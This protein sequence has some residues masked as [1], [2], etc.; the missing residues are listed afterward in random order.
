MC[1]FSVFCFNWPPRCLFGVVQGPFFSVAHDFDGPMG[2]RKRG[3]L[4]P[5]SE[6]PIVHAK[7]CAA[8]APPQGAAERTNFDRAWPFFFSGPICC[9][10]CVLEP[11][12]GPEK[13]FFRVRSPSTRKY[14]DHEA[15]PNCVL[16]ASF[17]DKTA[18]T[19][20]RFYKGFRERPTGVA[21]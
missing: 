14:N 17:R 12:V 8:I 11:P 18:T 7:S 15:C 10:H 20:A 3:A 16:V 21:N 1:I 9:V 19:N 13:A 2:A 5:P 6:T 4:Q